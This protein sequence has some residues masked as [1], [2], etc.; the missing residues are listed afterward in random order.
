MKNYNLLA[1]TVD[2]PWCGAKKGERCRG[3]RAGA[4][5]KGTHHMRRRLATQVRRKT[6]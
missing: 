1:R 4:H 6:S 3:A 5:N 2:C